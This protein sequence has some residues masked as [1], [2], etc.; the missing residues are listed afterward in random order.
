MALRSLLFCKRIEGIRPLQSTYKS[1][2]R[3][4][5]KRNMHSIQ[6]FVEVNIGEVVIYPK[7]HRVWGTGLVVDMDDDMLELEECEATGGCS[8]WEIRGDA[9]SLEMLMFRELKEW[10]S[11]LIQTLLSFVA[12]YEFKT[13]T[14]EVDAYELSLIDNFLQ[15][16]PDNMDAAVTFKI[17]AMSRN[18]ITELQ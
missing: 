6:S 9:R 4:C 13:V 11:V 18:C 8:H 17:F 14:T 2:A 3:V 15:N 10:P 1:R 7:K 12:P 5:T 16:N